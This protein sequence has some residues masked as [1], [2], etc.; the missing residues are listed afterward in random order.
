MR[1]RGSRVTEFVPTSDSARTGFAETAV[2]LRTPAVPVSLILLADTEAQQPGVRCGWYDA[3]RIRRTIRVL[4]RRSLYWL[5]FESVVDRP[6]AGILG[7]PN[8]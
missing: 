2:Y 3:I 1:G 7:V 4:V 5:V 8:N 6:K